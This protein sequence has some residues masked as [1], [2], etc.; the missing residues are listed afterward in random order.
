[1]EKNNN[2]ND[3]INSG[4]NAYEYYEA[5]SR[6]FEDLK[7]LRTQGAGQLI[8]ILGYMFEY[9]ATNQAI[10]LIEDRMNLR[11]VDFFA[12]NYLGEENEKIKYRLQEEHFRNRG[13][14]ADETALKAAY[15][16]LVGQT[17]ITFIDKIKLSRFNEKTEDRDYLI[18][19]TANEEI[20]IGA[21]LGELSLIFNLQG[22]LL[23]YETSNQDALDD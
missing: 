11:A 22:V 17:I 3:N 8:L 10:D 15:L 2:N 23:L 4:A 12:G 14:N 1:M 18:S 13:V 20:F 19:K 7:L 6:D 21:F 16:E 9:M 5:V